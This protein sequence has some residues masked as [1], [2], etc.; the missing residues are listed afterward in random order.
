MGWTLSHTVYSSLQFDSLPCFLNLSGTLQ[1]L[2]FAQTGK[3]AGAY[4]GVLLSA[5][6]TWPAFALMYKCMVGFTTLLWFG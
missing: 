3:S 4:Q 6:G 5:R 2:G 1:V